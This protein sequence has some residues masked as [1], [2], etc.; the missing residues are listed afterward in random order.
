MLSDGTDS[1]NV[2]QVIDAASKNPPCIGIVLCS[3]K[4]FTQC[5]EEERASQSR[6]IRRRQPCDKNFYALKSR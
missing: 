6:Y 4:Q 1:H 2:N 3:L 5:L